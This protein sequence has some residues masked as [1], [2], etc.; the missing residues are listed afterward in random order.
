MSPNPYQAPSVQDEKQQAFPWV[1]VS[2][3]LFVLLI[4]TGGMLYRSYMLANHAREQALRAMMQ[5]EQAERQAR[6][7]VEQ[8]ELQLTS[9]AVD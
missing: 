9:R 3:V 6:K 5:A 2:A 7:A 8:A 1:V 4:A